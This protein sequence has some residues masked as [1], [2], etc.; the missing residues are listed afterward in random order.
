MKLEEFVSKQKGRATGLAR[1]VGVTP[2]TI[3]E[4]AHGKKRVP[5][6]RC[7]DIERES[8]GAVRCEDLR[9]DIDWAYLRQSPQP[10]QEVA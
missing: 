5:F 10:A 8:A 6:K 7:L 4:W 2:V 1:A 3:H 9:P